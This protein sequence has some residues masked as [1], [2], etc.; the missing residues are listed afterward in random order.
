MKRNT[1]IYNKFT[2]YTL[3]DC[4]CKYCAFYGGKKKGKIVCLTDKCC[5]EEEKAD[6]EENVIFAGRLGQYKYFDMD[7][8]INSIFE[9]TDEL[10]E[11]L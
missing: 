5:C 11:D 6:C 10:Q 9:I 7:K 2:G 8:V 1:K 4:D 3:E